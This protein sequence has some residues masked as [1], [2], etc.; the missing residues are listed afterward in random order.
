M[1][2]WVQCSWRP[3]EGVRASGATVRDGCGSADVSVRKHY[4]LLIAELS[5]QLWETIIFFR[6]FILFQIYLKNKIYSWLNLNNFVCFIR[7]FNL[8][9]KSFFLSI[10]YLGLIIV[11]YNKLKEK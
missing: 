5:L 1:C 10:E 4:N 3:A 8:V 11:A 9:W 7:A 2:M 6:I